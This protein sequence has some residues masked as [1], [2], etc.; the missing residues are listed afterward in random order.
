MVVGVDGDPPLC[1][2]PRVEP[3][4]R[5]RPAMS[6]SH[7]AWTASIRRG[8]R[9]VAS[10]R[11]SAARACIGRSACGRR[12][13][14]RASKK[15][16]WC[17]CRRGPRPRRI[18]PRGRSPDRDREMRTA[19][20]LAALAVALVL[21]TTLAGMSMTGGTRVN[22]VLVAV[23]YRRA[24]VRRGDRARSPARPAASRRTRLPA[25]SSASAACRRRSWGFSSACSVRSSSCRSRCRGS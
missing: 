24:R 6:S 15:C 1:D 5:A 22:L 3:R 7:R 11:P 25:A 13:T 2:G 14:S 18:W 19:G 23:V 8:S 20:V 12:S 9:L 4:R 17:S 21:Q 10:S 16:W